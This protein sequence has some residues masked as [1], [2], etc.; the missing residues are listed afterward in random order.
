[1]ALFL[2]LCFFIQPSIASNFLSF[3]IAFLQ[4]DTGTV[5]DHFVYELYKWALECKFF[6]LCFAEI[7]LFGL[8]SLQNGVPWGNSHNTEVQ[9][10]AHNAQFYLVYF[11]LGECRS[12]PALRSLFHLA[13]A[14]E[15]YSGPSCPCIN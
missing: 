9:C 14:I 15:I 1:M 13:G 3:R 12:Q 6:H 2:G 7:R 11:L 4:E 5:P 10:H 8:H